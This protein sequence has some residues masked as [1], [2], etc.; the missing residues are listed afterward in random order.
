MQT[1]DLIS[2]F[3]NLWGLH[4]AILDA[5]GRDCLDARRWEI[6]LFDQDGSER[7][8]FDVSAAAESLDQWCT[9]ATAYAWECEIIH[10]TQED[11][12]RW[13]LAEEQAKQQLPALARQAYEQ[14][15][16]ILPTYIILTVDGVCPAGD[17]AILMCPDCE[18]EFQNAG[19]NYLGLIDSFE[20]VRDGQEMLIEPHN[21]EGLEDWFYEGW[22][23]PDWTNEQWHEWWSRGLDFAHQVKRLLPPGVSLFYFGISDRVWEVRPTG[24]KRGVWDDADFI[25]IE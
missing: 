15:R 11:F 6:V 2:N 24:E 19:G 22:V 14:L 10:Y 3:Q 25:L 20:I 18:D 9:A 12:D 17:S 5:E 21:I 4:K 23:Q 13:D 7:K 16:K 8:R 1:L